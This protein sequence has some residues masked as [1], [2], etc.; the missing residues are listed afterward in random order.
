MQSSSYNEQ[1]KI[2]EAT[3]E[4]VAEIRIRR[5]ELDHNHDN[6]VHV[7]ATIRCQDLSMPNY[8]VNYIITCKARFLSRHTPGSRH[9]IFKSAKR[10]YI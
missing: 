10:L 8:Y 5:V 9:Q 2:L 3:L 4:N 6:C 1:D 7:T